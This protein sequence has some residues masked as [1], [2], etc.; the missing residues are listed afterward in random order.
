MKTKLSKR[1]QKQLILYKKIVQPD[2][3][4]NDILL[5]ALF[6]SMYNMYEFDSQNE[7]DIDVFYKDFLNSNTFSRSVLNILFGTPDMFI[8]YITCCGYVIK[9]NKV[10]FVKERRTLKHIKFGIDSSIHELLTSSYVQISKPIMGQH[11]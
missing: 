10:L 6:E 5:L 1:S 9:E 2:N 4:V 11:N 7:V 8:K 3:T